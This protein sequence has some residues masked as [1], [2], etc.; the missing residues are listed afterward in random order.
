MV[1]SVLLTIL[2][3]FIAIVVFQEVPASAFVAEP[4]AVL[5]V[6]VTVRDLFAAA[7][8]P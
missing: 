7:P 3:L 6:R 5:I 4:V 2:N 1:V 8:G